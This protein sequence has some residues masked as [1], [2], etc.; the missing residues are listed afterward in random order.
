VLSWQYL[1]FLAVVNGE[2][3]HQQCREA[4]PSSSSKAVKYQETLQAL[5]YQKVIPAML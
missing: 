2:A 3:F 5:K 1:G 4:R